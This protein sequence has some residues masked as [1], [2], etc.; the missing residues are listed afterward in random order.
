[1]HEDLLLRWSI[2]IQDTTVLDL[3]EQSK[4]RD[5]VWLAKLS[6]V[7]FQ[8]WFPDSKFMLFYNGE[9][10]D[11]FVDLF[12]SIELPLI[13]PIEY[14][15]QVRLVKEGSLPNP[16]NFVPQGV[17]WKWIPFRYDIAYNEISID[18]DIVCI[19]EPLNWYKW[20]DSDSPIVSSPERFSKVLVNTCGDFF[21]HPVLKNKKPLNCG[22]VGQRKGH[23]YSERFFQITDEID[24]GYTRN[25]L[26]ITE[27][28]AINVWAYSLDGEGV[29]TFVLNYEQCSWIRD[30]IYYLDKGV[31][32]ETVHA[33]TWH[34]RILRYLKDIFERKALDDNYA[35]MEFMADVIART[36]TMDV[37]S[38]Q[39][40]RRQ[41]EEKTST[42]FFL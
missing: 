1:M 34:K 36:R 23:D 42:E 39:V 27:Q 24:Y 35:D 40:I 21:N 20:I 12:E 10:I 25:S 11:E 16:Y 28:G 3:A 33:T 14:V 30:F 2:G 29:E 15:D 32:V 37:H 26:F 18:T 38:R 31:K 5:A 9:Q 41:V 17:W 13:C 7:S 22:I 19:N 4:F 6:I 8:K